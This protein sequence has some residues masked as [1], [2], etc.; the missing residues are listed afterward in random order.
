MPTDRYTRFI[1]T[2]IAAC[3]LWLCA[4][5]TG[6]PLQAQQRPPL[7]ADARPQPVVV[8]GWGTVDANGRITLNMKNDQRGTTDPSL[9][10]NVIGY[11]APLQVRLDNTEKA[12]LPVAVSAIKR[13]GDWEPVRTEAEDA[14]VRP[15]PGRGD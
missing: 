10:V 13:V 6:R 15:R 4:A 2:L 1:L 14:P 9:P 7:A 3:L 12:P 5:N 8:V 11:P